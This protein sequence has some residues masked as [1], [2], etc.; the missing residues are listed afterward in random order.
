M[1]KLMFMALLS[2][3]AAQQYDTIYAPVVYPDWYIQYAQLAEQHRIANDIEYE[4][5][6]RRVTED[7][8]PVH[9]STSV[10]YHTH[11]HNTAE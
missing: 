11:Y 9:E 5:W 1:K 7:T 3:A 4:N 2:T 6:R 8:E 10:H